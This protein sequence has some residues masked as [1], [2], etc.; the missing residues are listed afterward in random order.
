MGL[1]DPMVGASEGMDF[2]SSSYR[3]SFEGGSPNATDV[4]WKQRRGET[5]ERERERERG[6]AF[7]CIPRR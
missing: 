4:K 3:R 7:S 6:I 2:I 1:A 5:M